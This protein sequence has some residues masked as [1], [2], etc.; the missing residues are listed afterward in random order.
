M[1]AVRDGSAPGGMMVPATEDSTS[2]RMLRY[3][4]RVPRFREASHART[5][6]GTRGGGAR[7]G[8]RGQVGAGRAG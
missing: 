3:A 4:T 1:N 5:C 6:A 2:V 8:R 7:R